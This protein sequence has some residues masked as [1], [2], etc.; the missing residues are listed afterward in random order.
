[1]ATKKKPSA[2]QLA[3][4]AK[5]VEM[6]RAKSKAKKSAPKKSASKKSATHKDTKSHN[7]NIT[8]TTTMSKKIKVT[9]LTEKELSKIGWNIFR[10]SGGAYFIASPLK[11]GISFTA[12]SKLTLRKKASEFLAKSIIK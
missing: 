6:V 7:V 2:A 4:R 9:P 3:A 1:M 8:K 12:L 5:F 10:H 11:E